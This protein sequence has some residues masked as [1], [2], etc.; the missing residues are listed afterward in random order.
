MFFGF[1][2]AHLVSV[3]VVFKVRDSMCAAGTMGGRIRERSSYAWLHYTHNVEIS[4]LVITLLPCVVYIRCTQ[5]THTVAHTHTHTHAHTG[6]NVHTNTER[7][8]DRARR[9]LNVTYVGI[10]SSNTLVLA[11]S[12]A[13]AFALLYHS[14]S[15]IG[16][17]ALA[18]STVLTRSSCW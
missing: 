15:F 8:T 12:H 9:S 17:Y 7:Y 6:R 14:V 16:V 13:Q 1:R 11:I 4:R 18:M 3:H 5:N 10:L 2:M